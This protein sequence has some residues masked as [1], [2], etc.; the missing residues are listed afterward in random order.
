MK[1]LFPRIQRQ[2]FLFSHTAF[3]IPAVVRATELP[4]VDSISN[5][6]SVA[7]CCRPDFVFLAH[8]CSGFVGYSLQQ[9]SPPSVYLVQIV[10]RLK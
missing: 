5:F 9:F 10:S 8:L 1:I 3:F 4:A 2:R 7:C 6:S